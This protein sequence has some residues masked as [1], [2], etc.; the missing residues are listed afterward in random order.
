MGS[1]SG[2]FRGGILVGTQFVDG[3]MPGEK[4]RFRP[5][6]LLQDSFIDVKFI[7]FKEILH[8]RLNHLKNTINIVYTSAGRTLR[9]MCES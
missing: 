9:N 3:K 1:G 2:S 7:A 5:R 6:Y 4:V 8:N